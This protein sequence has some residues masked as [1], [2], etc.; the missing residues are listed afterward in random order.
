MVPI[1]KSPIVYPIMFK[2]PLVPISRSVVTFKLVVTARLPL[3]SRFGIVTA[4]ATT[5]L[6]PEAIDRSVVYVV[7]FSASP[8]SRASSSAWETAPSSVL[9]TLK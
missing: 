3:T 6:F 1:V 2:F 7:R 9:P 5:V 4:P 8:V